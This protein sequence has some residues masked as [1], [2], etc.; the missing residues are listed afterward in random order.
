M[1]CSRVNL[2]LFE[3]SSLYLFKYIH[4]SVWMFYLLTYC[5]VLPLYVS[6]N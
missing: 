1:T 3:Y 2:Q 6:M 5:R 4:Y